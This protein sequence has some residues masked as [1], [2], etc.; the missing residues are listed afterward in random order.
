ML[1]RERIESHA[2]HQHAL[3]GK[4]THVFNINASVR[5]HIL[6][7]AVEDGAENVTVIYIRS[8]QKQ[9]IRQ[10]LQ[11]RSSPFVVLT[12]SCA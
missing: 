11:F 5:L 4:N 7:N 9:V 10:F 1:L 6:N 12:I 2:R 3:Y 8:V